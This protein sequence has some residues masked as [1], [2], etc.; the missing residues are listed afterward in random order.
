VPTYALY[1][2]DAAPQVLPEVL[3]NAMVIDAVT[4]R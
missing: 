4:R 1:R 3:S 2:P